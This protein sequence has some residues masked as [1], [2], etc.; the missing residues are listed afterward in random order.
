VRSFTSILRSS[1]LST[2]INNEMTGKAK[3][4]GGMT[5]FAVDDVQ[6]VGQNATC[7]AGGRGFE[8]RRSRHFRLEFH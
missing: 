7:R 4:E 3:A 6:F 1:F 2:C 8:S 5:I